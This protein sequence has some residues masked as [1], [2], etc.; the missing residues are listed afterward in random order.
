MSQ[1]E[2]GWSNDSM[3]AKEGGRDRIEEMGVVVEGS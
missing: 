3:V 1:E 2:T